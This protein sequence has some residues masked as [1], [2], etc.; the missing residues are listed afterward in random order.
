MTNDDDIEALVKELAALKVR[1]AELEAKRDML[2]NELDVAL[3]LS[4]LREQ[5]E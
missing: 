5:D 2:K 3:L 4:V 1:T